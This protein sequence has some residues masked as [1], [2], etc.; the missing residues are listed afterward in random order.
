MRKEILVIDDSKAI[1]FL[2]HTIL[3]KHYKVTSVPDGLSAMYYLRKGNNPHLIILDPDLPD[4]PD[5]ELVKQLSAS[6]I[7]GATPLIV[8]SNQDDDLTKANCLKYNVFEYY[9]KPFNPV[10]LLEAIDN[11]LIGNTLRKA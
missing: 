2:L 11:I 7:Y 8:I 9:L 10:N 4:L 1:R 3:K 6:G 5:W